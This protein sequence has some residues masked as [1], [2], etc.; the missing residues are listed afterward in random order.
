MVQ[1]MAVPCGDSP[2]A[3]VQ[4]GIF[5]LVHLYFGHF[6]KEAREPLHWEVPLL[7]GMFFLKKKLFVMQFNQMLA[8]KF[9]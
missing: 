3:M 5:F 2:S 6:E 9:C 4:R 1:C 8:P 7:F